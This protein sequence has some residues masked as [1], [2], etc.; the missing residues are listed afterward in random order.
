MQ[1][2]E[3][4]N[5]CAQ[6]ISNKLKQQKRNPTTEKLLQDMFREENETKL[7]LRDTQLYR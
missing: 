6:W 1:V 7:R 3:A 4:D 2:N 5:T